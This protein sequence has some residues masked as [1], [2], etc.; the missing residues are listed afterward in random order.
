MVPSDSV[1]MGAEVEVE[2]GE[3][4]PQPTRRSGTNSE[5]RYRFMVLEGLRGV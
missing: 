2:V 4:S 5:D 1:L 3:G